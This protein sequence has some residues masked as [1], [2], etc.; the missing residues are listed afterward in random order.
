MERKAFGLIIFCHNYNME[1]KLSTQREQFL[2][3]SLL[4]N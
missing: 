4:A 3:R 2:L 1:G